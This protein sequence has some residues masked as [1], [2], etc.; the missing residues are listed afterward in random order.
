MMRRRV[1][2]TTDAMTQSRRE[3]AVVWKATCSTGT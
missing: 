3:S 1:A 2:A